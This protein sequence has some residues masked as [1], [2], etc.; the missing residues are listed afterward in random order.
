[1]L[2]LP[3][4][5]EFIHEDRQTDGWIDVYDKLDSCFAKMRNSQHPGST[6]T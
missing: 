5:V 1:M 3:A 2:L 6:V 4:V